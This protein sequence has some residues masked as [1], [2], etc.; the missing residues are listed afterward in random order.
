MLELWRPPRDA[1]D[2]IGC[3]ATS[4]TF[5]PSLF[6][7][8]CLG[9]FLDLGSE[10]S[11][12]ELAFLLEREE[13]LGRSYAGVL[14]DHTQAGVE[15]SLRWDVLPV[16]IPRAKQHAKLSLLAWA[17][18]VRLIVAS[19][20][21]TEQGYRSNYEVAVALELSPAGA[22]LEALSSAIKFLESLLS[23]V[24]GFANGLPGVERAKGFLVTVDRRT[25]TWANKPRR[26]GLRQHLV[27]TSPSRGPGGAQSSLEETLRLC[28]KRGPSPHEAWVASPFFDRDGSAGKAPSALCKSLAR[29]RNRHVCFC[30]PGLVE[31]GHGVPRLLAPKELT[32]TS[33]GLGAGVSVEILPTQDADGNLRPWHAKM[34]TL[35]GEG[36]TGLLIGSSNFTA[37]G[38]GIDGRFN[39]EANL[40]TVAD[41]V[42]Y[43]REVGM[44]DAIWPEMEEVEDPDLAEWA[45]SA[46]EDE[47]EADAKPVPPGFVSATFHAS[48]PQSLALRLDGPHLP[49]SWVIYAA[50]LQRIEVLS[51]ESWGQRGSSAVFTF[52][53]SGAQPPEKLLIQWDGFEAFWPLNVDDPDALPVPAA[54]QGMSADDMLAI[55]AASDPSA[56]VRAWA[57]RHNDPS[58][59]FDSDLDSAGPVD[60]DPLRRFDI[61]A[62]F[63]HRVRR[64]ARTFAQM[65]A[66]L[67]RPIWSRQ[68][69]EWRLR[70]MIGI[71]ALAERLVRELAMADGRADEGLL[72]LADFLIVLQEV[73][74]ETA[75]GAISPADFSK[76]YRPFLKALA[77]RLRDQVQGLSG[78]LS[79]EPSA[80]WNRVISQCLG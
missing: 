25:K 10:P 19:A 78:R 23:F 52:P 76:V 47:G 63:L 9:R 6:D 54:L 31:E 60:L 43:G 24:P 69:L 48:P 22:D 17:S 68:G 26:G 46:E 40:L 44:L 32:T 12:E 33:E 73:K 79:D 30:V 15:H 67:Q 72:T 74:Y 11:R 65:R 49:R 66:N 39:V 7:E 56:A 45:G 37:A 51:S 59:T 57:R 1:G 2:A 80:F 61:Q 21:L 16:R 14:V 27:F 34:L 20:N 70:G 28:R 71:D 38:L 18:H 41:D 77:E 8:Q 35:K 55:L 36:Y 5:A 3:L 50:G 29:G 4:F 62:T 75:D 64:R 13:R 53:W 42:E 58:E